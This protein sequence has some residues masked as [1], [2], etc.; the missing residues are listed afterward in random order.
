MLLGST[1]QPIP[2]VL[3][4]GPFSAW[5]F[6][7][8]IHWGN[9]TDPF[10]LV[11]WL[12]VI[13]GIL[14][15]LAFLTLVRDPEHSPN[16]GLR[17]FSSLWWLPARFK[18]YLLAIGIFGI[19]DFSHSLLIMAATTLLTPTYG[20]IH[21]A[22]IAG[23]LYVWRNIVQVVASY[24]AGALADKVGQYSVLVSGYFMGVFTA[25][26]TVLAFWFKTDSIAFLTVI[27][28]VAGLYVAVQ[29]SLELTVTAEMVSPDRLAMSYGAL[30]TVNG[31]ARFISST[32]VGILWTTFSPVLGFGLAAVAMVSGTIILFVN[33]KK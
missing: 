21:A 27:F 24:P 29:E 22:Q 1:G 8:G 4:W 25:L 26:L 15:V 17:F 12:S 5:R 19:G 7:E 2:L 11:L 33:R 16:P 14:A 6:L 3:S 13:P 28:L 18:R 30:G 31:V 10:R 23:L 32:V 9:D 20:I